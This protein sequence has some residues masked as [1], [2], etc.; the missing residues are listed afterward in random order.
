MKLIKSI[1]SALL[2]LVRFLS[3]TTDHLLNK[4]ALKFKNVR[5]E[6]Y[7]IID[8]R[9][10]IL[11]K[12][13][14]SLGQ[15]VKFNCSPTS[16]YVGLFKNCSIY[17]AP[18]ARLTIG[19]ETGLSGVSIYCQQKIEIGSHVN[20]GG[21]VCIWD[22]DFHPLNYNDRRKHV[23]E[24]IG[25]APVIIKDD[26]FI[27]ANSIILKGVQIGEKSIIGA[28]SVVTKSVPDHEIWAGNPAKFIRK[29]DSFPIHTIVNTP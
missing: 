22:T 19:A 6:S 11:N 23:V 8:G 15:N 3:V 10:T 28:G 26:A 21:N 20:I 14:I 4:T 25:T 13:S 18:Q 2:S 12:G 1:V 5:Y 17:V 9:I 29:T 27:G 7:P 24:K 16:N